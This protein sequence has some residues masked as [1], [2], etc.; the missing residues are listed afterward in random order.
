MAVQPYQDGRLG[1]V[2]ANLTAADSFPRGTELLY[3]WTLQLTHTDAGFHPVNVMFGLV[4]VLATYVAAVRVGLDR[5][6]AWLAAGIVP[7][8]PI[9]WYMGTVGYIDLSVGGAVAAAAAMGLPE[10][11]RPWSWG[12]A[13]GMLM[14]AVLA[15]WMKFPAIAILG[16]LGTCRMLLTI[17]QW[18][19][20]AWRGDRPRPVPGPLPLA[21]ACLLAVALASVPYARAYVKYGNP[22]FPLQL[23]VGSHVLFEGPVG[24]QDIV[25]M[26]DLPVLQRYS[27]YWCGW[28]Y[29]P[30]TPDSHGAFG[31]LFSLAMVGAVLFCS[32]VELRL[33]RSGWLL[34]VASFWLFLFLPQ[35]HETR[36]ALYILLPAAVCTARVGKSLV[37][38]ELGPAWA[39]AVLLFAC[40]NV[41]V[42]ASQLAVFVDWQLKFNIPLLTEARNRPIADL[43]HQSGPTGPTPQTRRELYRLMRNGETVVTAVDGLQGLFWD[44]QYRYRVEHRPAK[45][46]HA[47]LVP[48]ADPK[49]GAEEAPAWLA[50]LQRRRIAAAMVYAGS[51]E[52]DMLQTPGS[53]YRLMY[54]Q[55][56]EPN[57]RAFRIY[58]RNEDGAGMR[59]AA[60]SPTS[61]TAQG[62]A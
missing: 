37:A 38:A 45:Q 42:L 36:Y 8:T 60:S 40:M 57:R 56:P 59:A 55:A 34:L 54:E 62:P 44:G 6:W 27:A 22:V 53:G 48:P 28:W 41:H 15:M 19:A 39:T 24:V 16:F 26:Y 5:G 12:S 11:N 43:I 49:H 13:I 21:G 18:I 32:L 4:F 3:Y 29:T 20:A 7:T 58:R 1:P 2:Q 52:D 35:H 23:A 9:F 46:W 10:R 31:P 50:G 30:V 14:A 61:H 33:R 17:G 47:C 25:R 51:A